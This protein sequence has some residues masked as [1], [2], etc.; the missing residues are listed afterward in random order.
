MK[1]DI[2]TTGSFIECDSKQGIEI[3]MYEPNSKFSNDY[4]YLGDLIEIIEKN[5]IYNDHYNNEIGNSRIG[6]ETVI[7]TIEPNF[8]NSFSSF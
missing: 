1:K 2:S 7:P 4:R 8:G 3:K 5:K 6:S